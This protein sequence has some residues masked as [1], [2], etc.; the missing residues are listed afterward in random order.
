MFA[1]AQKI[2]SWPLVMTHAFTWG[3]VKRR[4]W[5]ASASSMSTERSYELDLSSSSVLAPPKGVT[6]MMSRAISPSTASVQC[7]YWLGSVSKESFIVRGNVSRTILLVNVYGMKY[8][9]CDHERRTSSAA[10]GRRLGCPRPPRAA[11]ADAAR[12]GPAER[13]VGALPGRAG[14]GRGQHLRRAPPGRGAGA[15]HLRRRDPRGGPARPLRQARRRPGRA[16]RRGQEHHRARAGGEAAAAFRRVG[17]AG[18]ARRGPLAE[19]DL[20]PARRGIL[21]AARAR[22]PHPLS[23]PVRWGSGRN[24]RR[25]R[26][27]PR[28]LPVADE[29][30]LYYLG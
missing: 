26:H 6:F 24:G 13:P 23:R 28:G 4:R 12:T 16:A 10:R 25:H 18:R 20:L 2:F 21:S 3:C 8:T 19:R 30:L 9:A 15:G 14:D 22:S 27:R 7:R 5:M 11:R 29:A 1:P 17:R